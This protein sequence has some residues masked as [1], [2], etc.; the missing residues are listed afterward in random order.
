MSFFEPPPKPETPL[1]WHRILSPTASVKV[2]PIALG[3]ISLGNAW[4]ELFGKSEDPI[5]LLDTFFSLG[6]NFID[7][8]NTYNAEESE[9]LI[10]EWMEKRGNRDQMVIATKFGAG[11]RAY[12][13][14]NEPM[15]SNY[16]GASAKSMHI[17]VR[18][19]LRKLRTDYIDILYIHWWDYS[20]SVEELMTHLHTLVTARQVLYLGISDTPAWIVVKA[21]EFAR[22]NGL[23][24]F[25]VYQGRWNAAFRDLEAE[26]IP[27]CEDQG[28][29]I[30]SWASLGGGQL[31]TAEQRQKM[32]QDPDAP[33]G[34]G[35]NQFDV[36]VCE[37]LEKLAASKGATFQE[38][39]LTY[40]FHQSTYVFPIVGVQT[41]EHVKALPGAL[42]IKLSKEEIEQ[43]HDAAPFNPLFPHTFLFGKKYNTGLAAADQVNYQMAAWIDAPPTQPPYEPHT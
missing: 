42:R 6:G 25:S 34:Y 32:E 5:A 18:D 26:V 29:A 7:T 36:A 30:V 31:N 43:I 27:M 19:S 9:K 13:R 14:K 23:T 16:T 21:N 2:S 39:A 35:Y 8:A 17:S 24:P 12:N 10:G 22:K 38:I 15:Q 41:V 40:L 37:V 1:G 4:S 11:Y 28:M 33:K 20:V 3:G